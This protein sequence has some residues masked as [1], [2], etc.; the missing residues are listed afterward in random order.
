MPSCKSKRLSHFILSF[1]FG[2]KVQV[3]AQPQPAPQM[4][5]HDFISNLDNI[6]IEGWKLEGKTIGSKLISLTRDPAILEGLSALL[7]YEDSYH[8]PMVPVTSK[9]ILIT[10][11]SAYYFSELSSD[12]PRNSTKIAYK[13]YFYP[14]SILVHRPLQVD[15]LT[16]EE[17]DLNLPIPFFLVKDVPGGLGAEDVQ[18]PPTLSEEKQIVERKLES[19]RNFAIFRYLKPEVPGLRDFYLE[20]AIKNGHVHAPLA[21][22]DAKQNF[23]NALATYENVESYRKKVYQKAYEAYQLSFER[24]HPYA[25]LKMALLHIQNKFPQSDSAARR[26]MKLSADCGIADAQFGYGQLCYF[27]FGAPENRSELDDRREAFEYFS[28]AATL[29]NVDG[30]FAKGAMLLNSPREEIGDMDQDTKINSA[31]PLFISAA[32]K[33]HFPARMNV[34][35]LLAKGLVPN[36]SHRELK[37]FSRSIYRKIVES[38]EFESKDQEV[39]DQIFFDFAKLMIYFR[40]GNSRELDLAQDLLE[41]VVSHEGPFW[42]VAAVEL[43]KLLVNRSNTSGDSL[44]REANLR[45]ARQVFGQLAARGIV[46]PFYLSLLRSGKGRPEDYADGD[47]AT[48][49]MYEDVPFAAPGIVGRVIYEMPGEL[50]F[51][52]IQP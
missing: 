28:R 2:F 3:F 30:L 35:T 20:E 14:T 31:I 25:P 7:K 15:L 48:L 37:L 1:L 21:Q 11:A 26:L 8:S 51:E 42:E 38:D 10:E 39:H 9:P 32:E 47:D 44:K 40:S 29:G 45:I 24:G 46:H 43:S 22:G 13:Y 41:R 23:A 49:K 4:V 12:V 5:V 19:E 50:A 17:I 52:G 16:E 18:D 6:Q 36:L 33:G 27:H 34:A